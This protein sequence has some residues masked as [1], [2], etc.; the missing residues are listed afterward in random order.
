[1]KK[2][3]ITKIRNENRGITTNLT[4]IKGIIKEYSEQFMLKIWH[5]RW[6]GQIPRNMYTRKTEEIAKSE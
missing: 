6:N 1:M 4:K 3:L 2:T 5:S